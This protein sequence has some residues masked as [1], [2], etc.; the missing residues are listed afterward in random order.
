VK[1]YKA[2]NP[3]SRHKLNVLSWFFLCGADGGA[4]LEEVG[5]R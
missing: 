3:H 2:L 5:Y 4:S 1:V